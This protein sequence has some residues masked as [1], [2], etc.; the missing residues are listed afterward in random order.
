MVGTLSTNG[1]KNSTC[2]ANKLCLLFR[3]CCF[4]LVCSL[5][6]LVFYFMTVSPLFYSHAAHNINKVWRL[7]KDKKAEELDAQVPDNKAVL[8]ERVKNYFAG[9]HDFT[10]FSLISPPSSPARPAS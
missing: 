10:K 3:S 5:W 4:F 9:N 6:Y 8:A 2:C 1:G 7:H